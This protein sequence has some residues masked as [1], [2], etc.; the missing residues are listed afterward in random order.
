VDPIG[1]AL[2]HYHTL[3]AYQATIKSFRDNQG[4]IL[5]YYYQRPGLIRMEFIQP[6]NGAVLIYKPEKK[7]AYIWPFGSTK[8]PAVVLSPDNRLIQSPTG[9]KV[10]HSDI[11]SLLENVQALQKEGHTEAIGEEPLG[12]NTSVHLIVTGKQDAILGNVHRYH[13]WLDTKTEFPVKVESY[14]VNNH[15]I[16]TVMIEDVRINPVFP[17][18]FFNP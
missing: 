10:D 3:N 5:H 7:R 8:L 2:A 11:G 12:Q 17:D 14:D 6:H 9:Q 4:E 16:E 15:M 13:L 1:T 18:R